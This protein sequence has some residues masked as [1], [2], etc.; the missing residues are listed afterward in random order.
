MAS[1]VGLTAPPS[2][3]PGAVEVVGKP[4]PEKIKVRILKLK[5][6]IQLAILEEKIL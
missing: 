5:T 4:K 1:P 2:V 6:I 3:R